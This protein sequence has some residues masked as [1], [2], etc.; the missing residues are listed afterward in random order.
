M[1]DPAARDEVSRLCEVGNSSAKALAMADARRGNRE[2][3]GFLLSGF[4]PAGH[5]N[6]GII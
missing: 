6:L 4:T 1:N 2:S 3:V 5:E